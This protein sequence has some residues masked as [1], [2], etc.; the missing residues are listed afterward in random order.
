MSIDYSYYMMID[1]EIKNILS[2][3]NLKKE[4]QFIS[5]SKHI[6]YFYETSKFRYVFILKKHKVSL[7][8][9]EICHKGKNKKELIH[10][11]QTSKFKDIK[12]LEIVINSFLS[13]IDDYDNSLKQNINNL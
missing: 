11:K 6:N 7:G 10:W 2:I 8:A 1:K 13:F 3:W 5:P 12:E 9:H 4:A